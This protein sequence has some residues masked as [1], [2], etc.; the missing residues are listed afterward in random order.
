MEQNSSGATASGMTLR[1]RIVLL[2]LSSVVSIL[3]VVLLGAFVLS[4]VPFTGVIRSRMVLL[5]AVVIFLVLLNIILA[6]YIARSIVAPLQSCVTFAGQLAAGSLKGRLAVS[7]GG[8][9]GALASNMNTLAENLQ[10]IVSH[11]KGTTDELHAVDRNIKRAAGQVISATG[12]QEEAVSETTRTAGLI[13]NSVVRISQGVDQLADSAGETSSSILE[14]AASIEEVAINTDTLATSVDDVSSSVI[15]MAASIKGI[16]TNITNLLEASSTTASSV[17]QMDASI[18]QVEKSA[19]DTAVISETVRS[20]AANGLTSVQETIAGMQEIR[21]ASRI[22]AGVVEHL[23]LRVHDIGAILSVIDEVAEQTNLLALNAAII[24]AQAGEQGKGFAVVADE[25]KELAERTSSSTREIASVINGVQE[26]TGRAVAAINQ[27]ELAISAGE[28]LSERSGAALEKIVDGVQQAVQQINAIARATVEQAKGSQNI[29]V[30]MEQVEEMVEQ[31]ANS[32]KEH[33]RGSEMI[34][35]AVERMREMTSQVR[36]STREQSR[37]SALIAK[38][39]EDVT[40]MIE[41]IREACADQTVH[42]Q[43]TERMIENIRLASNATSQA[44]RVMNSAVASLE[45]QLDQLE[46]EMSGFNL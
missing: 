18:R 29:R 39:T 11:L 36:S 43:A 45:R 41:R 16:G 44:A 46:N 30:A 19:M 35:S 3:L 42:G 20:D 14:M 6:L 37:T 26:E 31:I 22:T 15:Q 1:A 17:A 23:S 5:F 2:S 25:I 38:A 28:E 8:E 24:A 7:C 12:L 21:K 33:D 4:E 9:I 27:A 34:T 13:N 10:R 40:A 32:A